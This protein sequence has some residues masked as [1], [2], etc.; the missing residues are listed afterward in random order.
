MKICGDTGGSVTKS[1]FRELSTTKD[2]EED[3][4]VCNLC[5]TFFEDDP[6]IEKVAKLDGE[7]KETDANC[8]P[9]WENSCIY[10]PRANKR[11][12]SEERKI[13][14]I[15]K[16]K[17]RKGFGLAPASGDYERH[18]KAIGDANG[19]LGINGGGYPRWELLE[20]QFEMNR[21]LMIC[22]P[23]ENIYGPG[24]LPF[25]ESGLPPR[26]NFYLKSNLIDGKPPKGVRSNRIH[27]WTRFCLFL[28]LWMDNK[29]NK[30]WTLTRWSRQTRLQYSHLSR[31]ISQGGPMSREFGKILKTQNN[32]Y[33]EGQ[34]N[35]D[36]I[37]GFINNLEDMGVTQFSENELLVIIQRANEIITF[38]NEKYDKN[39][40]SWTKLFLQQN[41][42]IG[43]SNNDG[44]IESQFWWIN[45]NKTRSEG[46]TMLHPSILI[47]QVVAQAVLEVLDAKEIVAASILNVVQEDLNWVCL[48]NGKKMKLQWLHMMLKRENINFSCWQ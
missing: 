20:P 42:I 7:V 33:N 37:K 15:K 12:K 17:E 29:L 4:V 38:M 24:I 47:G 41:C 35:E 48:D 19:V 28:L 21:N 9:E 34:F 18:E 40:Y 46:I 30:P 11:Q 44:W 22:E 27:R 32:Q 25:L 43:Y 2:F 10:V 36:K 16:R 23:N 26:S 45:Q 5:G 1:C 14:E 6:R 31:L 3:G 13:K 8:E 39:N